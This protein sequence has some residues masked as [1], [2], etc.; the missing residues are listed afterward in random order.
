MVKPQVGWRVFGS[1]PPDD[2]ESFFLGKNLS[3]AGDWNFVNEGQRGY[4]TSH[5]LGRCEEELIIFTA[6]ESHLIIIFRIGRDM[7]SIK[8][9]ERN[10]IFPDSDPS[11]T[12][13]QEMGCV[14]QE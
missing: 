11:S 13:L 5:L 3:N 6:G 7:F 10:L 8:P 14:N 1:I 4:S 12:L 2:S 9:R